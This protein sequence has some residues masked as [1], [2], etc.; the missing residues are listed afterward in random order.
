MAFLPE[1]LS[2][3]GGSLRCGHHGKEEQGVGTGP[4]APEP[5]GNSVLILFSLALLKCLRP[6]MIV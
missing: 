4:R 2:D 3:G 5:D 1:F 6:Q